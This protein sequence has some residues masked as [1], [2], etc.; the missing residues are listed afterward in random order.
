MSEKATVKG[1]VYHSF[2]T[3]LSEIDGVWFLSRQG[4]ADAVQG[5]ATEF[6]KLSREEAREW[7]I[8]HLIP[9][10]ADLIPPPPCASCAQPCAPDPRL[11]FTVVGRLGVRHMLCPG[12]RR[13]LRHN[14]G[15]K[16]NISRLTENRGRN[17]VNP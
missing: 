8:H 5:I 12:C 11:R 9:L 4:D 15:P 16:L 3:T 10:P 1:R 7:L 13:A 2:T 17:E 14:I 6:R